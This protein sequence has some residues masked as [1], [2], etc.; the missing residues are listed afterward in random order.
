MRK[1]HKKQA[2]D[3][4]KLLGQAHLEIKS[5]LERKKFDIA[6]NLLEQCQE[7]AIEL[8]HMIEESEGE[9]FTAIPFLEDYCEQLYQVHEAI[10][11]HQLINAN[12]TCRKLEKALT[13]VENSIRN[14][15]KVRLEM[16]F[17]PYKASMWDSLESV[18]MAADADPDCDA[19]VMPIPY[20]DR[21]Q[22]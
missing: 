10:W 8:G 9:G 22:N 11:N 3:F 20:Y 12:K 14:D 18:W 2:E 15:I 16:V 6:M 19:Y 5:A 17:L 13:P 1:M 21:I 7:G 4:V